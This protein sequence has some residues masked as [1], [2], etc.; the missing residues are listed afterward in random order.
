[1]Y[2]INSLENIRIDQML[3]ARNA[4]VSQGIINSRLHGKLRRSMGSQDISHL[5]GIYCCRHQLGFPWV[6]I[7]KRQTKN[8]KERPSQYNVVHIQLSTHSVYLLQG[9]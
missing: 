9:V 8:Q 1:M 2:P 7:S 6:K 4:V 3:S 5:V